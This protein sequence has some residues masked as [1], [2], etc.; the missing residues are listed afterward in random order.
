MPRPL[1]KALNH[2]GCCA[3]LVGCPET[4]EALLIDPKVGQEQAYAFYLEQ[5]RL[6]L[7]ALCDTHTHADH[8]SAATRFMGEGITLYMSANTPVDRPKTPLAHGDTLTLG[9]LSF[10]ALAVPGHTAD[11]IALHGHGMVF[12]GDSLL[13]DGLGRSDFRGSDPAQLFDSVVRELLPLDEDTLVFPGHDYAG[14]LFST[15][16]HE[17]RHNPALKYPDGSAYAGALAVTEGA[18]NS[19]EVD[20]MLALNVLPDPELPDSPPVATSC[21]TGGVV[22]PRE[23]IEQ[24][25]PGQAPAM[26]DTLAGPEQWVD[27]RDPYEWDAGHIAG[28][29]SIPLSELGFHL[30]ELRGRDPL[31]LSCRTGVRSMTAAR[32]LMRLGVEHPVNLVGG[33]EGWRALELPVEA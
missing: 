25:Q 31:V 10:T 16:G 12:T 7:T 9:S 4:R 5:Y 24:L 2:Q 19:P 8:L 6:H 26:L 30:D 15:I 32:T 1:I 13:I 33:I 21:S 27:V 29:S 17:R 28:T 22:S 18:G 20:S 11:S 14:L 23:E 3:Y